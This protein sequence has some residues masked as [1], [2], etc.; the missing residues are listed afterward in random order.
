[1]NI[2]DSNTQIDTSFLLDPYIS[3]EDLYKRWDNTL[4][5]IGKV[6]S[7]KTRELLAK[8]ICSKY[9]ISKEA[10]SSLF[11]RRYIPPSTTSND[12]PWRSKYIP[13]SFNGIEKLDCED[14]YFIPDLQRRLAFPVR[15]RD[16]I[17]E[18]GPNNADADVVED[19]PWCHQVDNDDEDNIHHAMLKCECFEP[20]PNDFFFCFG[21]KTKVTPST[22]D[23]VRM[24][25]V[26]NTAGGWA[27]FYC[28][29]TCIR[30]FND[31]N[32]LQDLIVEIVCRDEDI[33]TGVIQ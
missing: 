27:S 20:I 23:W 13:I 21:C 14:P 16:H 12:T 9:G 26:E 33:D 19:A 32:P 22:T 31:L 28:S 25:I 10:I 8:H 11:D 2:I 18:Y 3:K 4:K 5:T 17:S 1:M 30:E 29:E 7:M 24:P 15:D 6:P